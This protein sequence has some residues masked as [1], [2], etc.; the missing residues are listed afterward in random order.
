MRYFIHTSYK[1]T[2]Y[3]GWQRQLNASTV[4]QQ[5][6]E[7]ISKIERKEMTIVGCGRTDAGVHASEYY[8]HI[9]LE[10]DDLIFYRKKMN[11]I[12]PVDISINK[13]IEVE[14]TAHARFDANKR[15][16]TYYI[17]YKKNPFQKDYQW[18]YPYG[19]LDLDKL[20]TAAA[21][22]MKHK[23]FYTFCKSHT[24]VKTM[25][26]DLFESI[27][28]QESEDLISYHISANRFLRGMVRLIVGMCINVAN[29]RLSLEEV[30]QAL[31][32]QIRLSK[33]YSVPAE[34]LFLSRVEYPYLNGAK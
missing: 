34:G 27:W 15:G 16:Y 22:L 7:A 24:D 14:E 30:D 28:K 6:E 17:S 3:A 9:D 26:C 29:N 32:D 10:I 19:K 25:N 18:Y 13:F 1:G 5:I 20:N 21:I 8:F 33:S 12:L 4:Q 31:L 23:A 2:N 11:N